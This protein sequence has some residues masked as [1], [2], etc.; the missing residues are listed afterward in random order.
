[1][2]LLTSEA[3]LSAADGGNV[4]R[5]TVM[6]DAWADVPSDRGSIPLSSTRREKCCR[7]IFLEWKVSLETVSFEAYFLCSKI[8]HR[9]NNY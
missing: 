4:K 3:C 5:S 9:Y 6:G 2:K 1:M 8:I 7:L